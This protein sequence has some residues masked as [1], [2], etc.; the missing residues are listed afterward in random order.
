MHSAITMRPD[1][2]GF[3]YPII[4]DSKCINCG[5]CESVCAFKNTKTVSNV[6]P[7]A[8]AVRHKNSQEVETSQSGAAFI[9]LS[10]WI[11]EQGGIVY[12]AGYT[13]H[14]YV[15]HKRAVTKEERNEFKGSKYVQSDLGD[16]FIQVKNDLKNGYIVLFSGTP[17]QTAGLKSFIGEKWQNNLFLV[18]IICHGVP[19]PY[20][21]QDYLN[22]LESKEGKKLTSV[23]FRDKKFGWHSHIE[24]FLFDNTYTYTYTFYTHINLRYSCS[25]CP[26]TNLNRP[27]DLTIGDCWGIEKTSAASL[28]ADEKGYSIVLINTCKG[29]RL[30]ENVKCNVNSTLIDIN[31]CL[32]PNLRHPTLL[33]KKRAKYEYDYQRKGLIYVLKKYGNLGWRYYFIYRPKK[34]LR[35]LIR[36]IIPQR[37]KELLKKN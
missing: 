16:V 25:V 37:L 24:S 2:L 23:N 13:N 19:S 5:L 4:D 18:D 30:F 31:M 7:Q 35:C 11:L 10:D 29:K 20:I 26:Y 27:S 1:A 9:A 28:A 21:W 14:F 33:H 17:C 3:L 36:T 22:Y 12:G 8:F 34:Q 6:T 32:Q 15:I